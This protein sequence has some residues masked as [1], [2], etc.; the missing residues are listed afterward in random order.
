MQVFNSNDLL[1]IEGNGFVEAIVG[2]VSDFIEHFTPV[3]V[4]GDKLQR[5]N[6]SNLSSSSSSHLSIRFF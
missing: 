2:A 5:L 3:G 6:A 4:R 1:Y